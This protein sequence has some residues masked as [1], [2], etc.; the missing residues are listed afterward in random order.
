[1]PLKLF[2][3]H[4]S[5]C[6]YLIS[7]YCSYIIPG[8]ISKK[9]NQPKSIEWATPFPPTHSFPYKQEPQYPIVA[10]AA[11]LHTSVQYAN[12]LVVGEGWC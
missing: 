10:A 6:M 9:F 1:M 12:V 7:G 4:Y 2:S 11:W 3:Q 8:F 5:D